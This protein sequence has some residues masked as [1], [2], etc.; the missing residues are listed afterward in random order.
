MREASFVIEI[1]SEM[2]LSLVA[3]LP[4]G[5]VLASDRPIPTATALDFPNDWLSVF[6]RD[7]ELEN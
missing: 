3:L 4:N 5:T 1:E 7:C 6:E 2:R